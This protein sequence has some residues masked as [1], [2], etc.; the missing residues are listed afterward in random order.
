MEAVFNLTIMTPQ[1]TLYEGRA[2]SLVAPCE[3]G[4][5]GVLANHA[6]LI[7][8]VEKGKIMVRSDS[9][10]QKVFYAEGDGFLEVL[11]NSVTLILN[12]ALP[13]QDS[14]NPPNN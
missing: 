1:A 13:S 9:N 2:V 4:Y 12:T 6:P 7:A 5:L 3:L 14:K 8:N 11:Q 10:E